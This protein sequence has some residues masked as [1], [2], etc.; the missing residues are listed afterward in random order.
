MA[1]VKGE[2][3]EEVKPKVE[4]PPSSADTAPCSK[5]ASV[6]AGNSKTI[7]SKCGCTYTDVGNVFLPKRTKRM[8]RIKRQALPFGLS[9]YAVMALGCLSICLTSSLYYNWTIFEDMF[10]KQGIL[11]NL[12]TE[13]EIAEAEPETF[14]CDLQRRWI[15]NLYSA[16][17]YTDSFVGIIGGYIGDRFGSYYALLIGQCFGVIAFVMFYK[18]TYSVITL[19]VTFFFWGISCSFALGPT[20]HYSRM[21]TFG[22]NMAVSMITGADNLSMFTPTILK[23]IADRFDIGFTGSSLTYIFWAVLVS[24]GTTLYFIPRRFIVLDEEE[25]DEDYSFENMFNASFLGAVKDYRY[26][27]SVTCYILLCS[28]R[29]FYRR[30]FTLLFFDNEEVTEFLEA[31]SD[32]SFVASFVLGYMNEYFGVATMM[33]LTTAM[34]IAALLA[35][36]FR[37]FPCA[38]T[39]ALLFSIAQA[40]DIQQLITFIDEVFPEHESTLMGVANIS[41]TIFGLILQF[42]FNYIFDLCGAR[43]TVFLMI[44]ILSGVIFL[45]YVIEIG[46]RAAEEERHMLHEQH[47]KEEE[48][49]D[50][51]EGATDKPHHEPQADEED[52]SYNPLGSKLLLSNLLAVILSLPYYVSL[53]TSVAINNIGKHE[54][55]APSDHDIRIVRSLERSQFYTTSDRIVEMCSTLFY[56]GLVM[57]L[58]CIYEYSRVG[59]HVSMSYSIAILVSGVIITGIVCSLVVPYTQIFR[60]L[61]PVIVV[62]LTM[63]PPIGFAILGYVQPN[64]AITFRLMVCLVIADAFVLFMAGNLMLYM[65]ALMGSRHGVSVHSLM[66]WSHLG[67][68]HIY[69]LLLIY[70]LREIYTGGGILGGYTIA[71]AMQCG[72][73]LFGTAVIALYLV[74]ESQYFCATSG[75]VAH[76]RG[77]HPCLSKWSSVSH[78]DYF[79]Q[80]V[81]SQGLSENILTLCFVSSHCGEFNSRKNTD[82]GLWSMSYCT[83]GLISFSMDLLVLSVSVAIGLSDV[84]MLFISPGMMS[85][86]ATCTACISFCMR[87]IFMFFGDSIDARGI[88]EGRYKHVFWP[89]TLGVIIVLL[90]V[91]VVQ[92]KWCTD[93]AV[94][95]GVLIGFCVVYSVRVLLNCLLQHHMLLTLERFKV[96]SGAT[97][98]EHAHNTVSYMGI[99]HCLGLVGFA[100]FC[101]YMYNA[102]N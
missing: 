66:G 6:D 80:H 102:A 65:N 25:S 75:S 59:G 72:V 23:V 84:A 87:M 89:S 56:T 32:L 50:K 90:A 44:V 77:L 98:Y 34:Y 16:I 11:S 96:D 85:Y 38:Y 93:A 15:S 64:A 67:M 46:R 31:A 88:E 81:P 92:F 28:V 27:L 82:Y 4:V 40:G 54:P 2:A 74:H 55:V 53:C 33:G 60:V 43:F 100:L 101:S 9:K 83:T 71:M 17:M 18:F 79:G 63:L 20:W 36:Y 58:G 19:A 22:N 97:K 30:S 57:L 29:L 14:V 10:V 61:P 47:V 73:T 70:T 68:G 21:F 12:C 51:K 3:K 48:E 35:I 52:T 42:L 1:E 49:E 62:A 99:G 86:I 26:W 39:S 8:D 94:S 41:N 7:N 78:T 91:N 45:C 13:E 95:T 76:C 37:N 69:C 5:D 24:L